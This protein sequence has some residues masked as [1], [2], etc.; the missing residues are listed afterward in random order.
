M[1][2]AN[3]MTFDE[4][5]ALM[6]GKIVNSI[7][8]I[9]MLRNQDE[10]VYSSFTCKPMSGNI[11]VNAVSGGIRRS[12][13]LVLPNFNKEY[14]PNSNDINKLWI[15]TKFLLYMGIID[16]ITKKTI[17]FPQG[18]YSLIN[19][20]LE[21]VSDH[22][23]KT[24]NIKADDKWS[25]LEFPIGRVYQTEANEALDGRVRDILSLCGDMKEP[26]IEYTTVTAPKVLRWSETDTYGKALKDLAASW[27][28][29]VF[30]NSTGHL[31]FQSFKDISVLNNVWDFRTDE[32]Q[33]MGA[34]RTYK[35]SEIINNIV[36]IGGTVDTTVYKG[37]ASNNDLTS[38]VR[39]GLIGTKTLVINDDK[40][41][42]ND[43][44]LARATMELTRRTR[45]QEMI[46]LTSTPLFHLDVNEAITVVDKSI[47]LHRDRYSLQEYS[48]DITGRTAMTL[49]AYKFND[50]TEYEDRGNPS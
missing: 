22:T 35:F 25:I 14:I 39:I 19:S 29:E 13:N 50:I 1:S 15:N 31:V 4:Y 21:V 30:Y 6:K 11:T 16:P 7:V 24:V 38:N 46:S 23:S 36:V 41:L 18:L 26:I 42:T 48:L 12:C 5:V 20:D 33:Y 27:S 37:E 2:D 40:I 8:K 49:Q 43:G 3:T 9:E 47:N 17:F 28:M 45:M 44:A 34:T 32:V 10:S